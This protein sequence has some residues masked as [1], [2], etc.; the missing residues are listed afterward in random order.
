[1][2]M[3]AILTLF[4]I[5][6]SSGTKKLVA[7][8]YYFVYSSI[9]GFILI[10]ST[11]GIIEANGSTTFRSLRGHLIPWGEGHTPAVSVFLFLIVAALLIKIPTG[12]FYHWL[13]K[14]HVEAS[15]AGSLVLAAIMLKMPA[16]GL[17]RIIAL[18]DTVESHFLFLFVIVCC[19]LAV[20]ACTSQMW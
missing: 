12:P 15:T 13:L 14:A 2:E 19:L 17:I 11:V 16:Y 4:V 5:L 10:F 6:S 7:G 18:C 3:S 1:M 20:T 9:S 8:L